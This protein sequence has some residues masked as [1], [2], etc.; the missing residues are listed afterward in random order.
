MTPAKGPPH[1]SAESMSMCGSPC[2]PSDDGDPAPPPA[3]GG[4]RAGGV[5]AGGLFPIL[6]ARLSGVTAELL[7]F[8]SHREARPVVAP[9]PAAV[10]GCL[11]GRD[12]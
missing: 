7:A 6:S 1:S 2:R 8:L 10:G 12:G 4:A 5:G 3:T 11:G 9:P